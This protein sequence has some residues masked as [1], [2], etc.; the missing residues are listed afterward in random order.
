MFIGLGRKMECLKDKYHLRSLCRQA[1]ER[2]STVYA[3]SIR[4]AEGP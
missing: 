4:P 3:Q 2:L 1:M